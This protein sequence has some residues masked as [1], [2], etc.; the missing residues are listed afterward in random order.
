MQVL[1]LYHKMETYQVML[2]A[3]FGILNEHLVLV[4]LELSGT[5]NLQNGKIP[6]D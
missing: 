2:S 5:L 4:L 6:T 3:H 1:F